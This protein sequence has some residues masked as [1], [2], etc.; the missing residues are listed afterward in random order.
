MPMSHT[1]HSLLEKKIISA[2]DK[3]Y[4]ITASGKMILS[5]RVTQFN[6]S[7]VGRFWDF[8]NLVGEVWQLNSSLTVG[9]V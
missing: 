4:N 6:K 5:H 3:I 2:V 9:L 1:V 7:T 8:F